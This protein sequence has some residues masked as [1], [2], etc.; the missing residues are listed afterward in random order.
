MTTVVDSS[1]GNAVMSAPS[2]T[3]VE[4]EPTI[5]VVDDDPNA[6][7]SL[8]ALIA[9]LGMNVEAFS[10]AEDFLASYDGSHGCLITDVR[11]P[12]GMWGTELQTKVANLP[13]PI[14]VVIITAFP[15]TSLIV[16]AMQQGAVTVLEKPY[17]N[18]ELL[19]ATQRALRLDRR[20]R[21]KRA[22]ISR[23][24]ESLKRLSSAESVVLDYIIDGVTNKVIAKRLDV[25]IR[26]IENRRKQIY[27]K[28]GTDSTAGLVS[29]VVEARTRR[30]QEQTQ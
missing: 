20:E 14:P 11:M 15:E 30:S 16:K 26:T 27:Q 1:Y 3:S 4:N 22:S 23:V 24:L 6:R 10:S 17:R 25:S 21:E 2:H 28:M 9:A 29:M 19:E 13:E 8:T 7:Q 18:H 12:I 5:Y